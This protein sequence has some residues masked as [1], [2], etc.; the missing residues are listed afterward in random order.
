MDKPEGYSQEHKDYLDD[1][2]WSEDTNMW[3][4]GRWLAREFSIPE[5]QSGNYLFYWMESFGGR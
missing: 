3:E 2:R 1:L 5:K 4:A